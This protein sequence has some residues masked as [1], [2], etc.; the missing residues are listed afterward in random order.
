ME[1]LGEIFANL[2]IESEQGRKRKPNPNNVGVELDEILRFGVDASWGSMFWI[3]TFDL[4]CGDL[5][6]TPMMPV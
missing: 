6:N 5:N 4:G 1:N 2:I 3:P